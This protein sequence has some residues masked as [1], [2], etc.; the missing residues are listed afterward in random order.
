MN[1]YPRKMKKKGSI[2]VNNQ[3]QSNIFTL[4]TIVI[5]VWISNALYLSTWAF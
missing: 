3:S 4:Y 2:W 5:W 1:H